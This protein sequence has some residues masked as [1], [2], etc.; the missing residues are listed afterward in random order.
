MQKILFLM[1]D[2]F[3]EIEFTAVFDIL[4]RGGVKVTLAGIYNDARVIGSHG[5][6]IR[7]DAALSELY[8][9]NYQG[10]FLPGGS[11]GVQNLSE[12]EKVIQCVQTFYNEGK[13]VTAIC[14]APKI[15]AQAKIISNHT[16]TSYPSVRS[17]VEPFCKKY[18]EERVVKDGFIITSRSAGT[19]EEFALEFLKA[20][21]GAPMA[22]KIKNQILAR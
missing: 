6:S 13:W 17:E 22:T 9:G 16:V 3:E 8:L 20:L 21:D 7:A 10:L 19:A 4:I 1:A 11:L 5:L 2:G 14:A 15:L 12:C 18:S